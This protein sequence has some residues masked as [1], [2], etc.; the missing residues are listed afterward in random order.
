MSIR[1]ALRHV[2][3]YRYDRPVFLGPQIVRLRPAPHCRTPIVSYSLKVTPADNFCNWQ[4]DPVGNYLARLVFTEP[5]T[6][7]EVGVELL[8]DMVTIN[9]FDFFVEEAAERWPFAYAPE[10]ITEL[11][12]YRLT[13]PAGPRLRAW[14]ATVPRSAERTVDFLVELNR[15]LQLDIEY[16]IRME[17][18]VQAPEETLTLGRGSCRDSAWLLVQ[19]L[20]HLGLAA[21]FVSGYLIQLVPDVK[22]VTGPVGPS[23]DFTDLHAWAEVYIPGAGWIGLDPTSG[24]LAGEG[25]L[26]LACAAEPPSAAPISG[27]VD[28][29]EVEFSHVMEV[30]R[31]YEVPTPARAYDDATWSAI[32][33]VGKTIDE[34]LAAADVRL[35]MGGEP[36]FV[37]LADPD[38][39]EWNTAAM[40][41]A[42]R[43]LA[44]DLSR[45]LRRRYAPGS[46]LHTGQGKWYPGEPLPRWAFSCFWRVDGE[47]VWSRDEYLADDGVDLGHGEAEAK[48]FV[49]AL[50]QR[51]RLEP[52]LAQPGYEDVWYWCWRERRLPANVDPLDARLDEVED[53]A[54]LARIFE[55]GLRHIVGYALP[56]A[57]AASGR[58]TGARWVMRSPQLFLLPGDSPMGFRLPLDSLPW[59]PE[60]QRAYFHD[61]D[62]FAAV[63]VLPPRAAL[64]GTTPASAAG[65]SAHAVQASQPMQ[66]GLTGVANDPR[67]EQFLVDALPG[68]H[69]EIRTALCVEPRNGRLHVFLPPQ[70]VLEDYLDLI[71]A[72][73]ET[74]VATGL[75]ILVEG[76]P[77]PRDL[78]LRVLSVTPDPGVIE[79]NVPP[80]TN[81]P[82]LV[83]L[84]TG[85]YEEARQVGLGAEK[86]LL[87][88][89]HVGSGGGNHL[90]LGGATPADSPFLRR[91]DLLRSL[92]AYWHN[93]P[94]L[95]FLFS[96]LFI[97][98]T[99]QAPRV[100]QARDDQV[101]ELELAFTELDRIAARGEPCA[102]WLVD[103]IF[104]NLLVDVTGNTHRSE[105]C[106]DKLYSP[107]GPT[108]RLGV[109]ELRAFEMPPHA[110]AS[111]V[112]QVLVRA[113]V[114]RFWDQPYRQP[115]VHWGTSIHDRFLLPHWVWQDFREVVRETADV[116]IALRTEW[117]L[118]H[119]EFRFP[120]V[121]EVASDGAWLELRQ[122]I[123]PW[124]VLG[125]EQGAGG[126]ARYVDSS[127]ERLQ[128]LGRG[129]IPGRH[130]VTCN[131]Q[132]V[133][134]HPT[135]TQGEFVAGVRYRAWQAPH[136]LHP[137]IP[138]DTPLEFAL[139]DL[140]SGGA[141]ARCSYH[142]AHPGG[143]NPDTRPVNALEAEG[144][145]VA[146]FQ[147]FGN[148]TAPIR[149]PVAERDPEFPLTLDLR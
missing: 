64:G 58:W 62:P 53:R 94:S 122:A 99:S 49:T 139:I 114:A 125:E 32:D 78:R 148:Q 106:I 61:Q 95:S 112:Q 22:P 130:A 120:Q 27:N 110:H 117:F 116:G 129:L 31:V 4:Q 39:D 126:T 100:D 29:C 67:A 69:Q 103:R 70:R 30:T 9:P 85:I 59:I 57:R 121:G 79:V 6:T 3:S 19:I 2:T 5:T 56:L 96:S 88:G 102:P 20:R 52:S 113:L 42:K 23:R 66:P 18:G 108:G 146:R 109:V 92:L 60:E 10:S 71:A 80:S 144:R 115:L 140:W 77:P 101:H 123:E 81:W 141:V 8:V 63:D 40:G 97:G 134:L 28:S 17:A 26:P 131:G 45:R 132:R 51:L 76:Y 21:R 137:T 75:P 15:R 48:R 91:P 47:P 86:F 133:P 104:R 43:A 111:L 107:D 38:G 119:W 1:V 65:P 83:D 24:L 136:S 124:H 98:P 34:R 90:A 25:H 142:V 128:V 13:D 12:P 35:T 37:S 41:P 149:V 72:V 87:D 33:A 135:G 14:L 74:A 73:E 93:H 145:R 44:A 16:V 89:R 7:F 127:L 147:A 55:Q 36:T 46:L 138:I 50:A 118:P 143:R 68:E 54:S 82:E 105:F 84:A 11:A